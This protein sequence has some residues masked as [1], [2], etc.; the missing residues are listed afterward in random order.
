MGCL[1]AKFV[2]L[3][4]LS[5]LCFSM[6]ECFHYKFPISFSLR[7]ISFFSIWYYGEALLVVLTNY[8]LA[9]ASPKCFVLSL[10]LSLYMLF[11]IVIVVVIVAVTATDAAAASFFHFIFLSFFS[12]CVELLLLQCFWFYALVRCAKRALLSFAISPYYQ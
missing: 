6:W 11:A 8:A 3:C 4:F 9:V 10:S 1:V 12:F 5:F 2:L 7:F